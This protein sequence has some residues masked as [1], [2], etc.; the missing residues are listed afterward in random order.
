VVPPF[1]CKD[2]DEVTVPLAAGV[3]ELGV[4][5]GVSKLEGIPVMVNATAELKPPLL[6]TVIV[7]VVLAS[8]TSDTELGEAERVK[9]DEVAAVTVMVPA[10]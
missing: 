1:V 9:V 10:T 8:W 3:T 5:F 2:R 4:N 7:S 6:V